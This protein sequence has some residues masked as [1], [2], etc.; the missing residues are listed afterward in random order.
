ME[1][2]YDVLVV[3]SGF[4]GSV[5]AL[6]LSE[7]GYRVAV[8]EQ[9]R[10]ISK[11]DM[12]RAAR[13][14][15]H[16]FWMPALHWAG[17]FT[18][19]FFQHVNVVGGV[20]VGGGSLVY[21][22]VLL[23]PKPGFFEHPAWR[24]LGVNWKERLQPYYT[25]AAQM[26]GRTPNPAFTQMDEYLRSTAEA[27]GAGETFGPAPLGIYFGRPGETVLDPFFQE[28]GPTRTGCIQCGACL[29]GCPH[30]A[31]N[32]LDTN[33]L[34]LAEARGAV[35]LPR[36]KAVRIQPL[37]QGGYEVQASDPLKPGG[38]KRTLRAPLVVLAAG[39]LGTLELLFRCRDECKTLPDLSPRLGEIVRTNSEAIVGILSP[40][41]EADLSR[42]PT[43]SS[44]FYVGEHT[45]I[46]QNRFPRGYSFMKWYTGPLVD[47]EQP[48]RRSL[49]SLF[50]F[51]RHPLQATASF[52]AL[53][54]YRRIS[55]LTVMQYLDNQISF[56]WS[57][58]L[59]TPL[60]KRLQSRPVPGKSAP[61]YLPVAN[62]VA[63]LFAE[64]SGGIP[65]NTLLESLFNM[66]VTAHI[67]GGCPIGKDSQNGVVDAGHEV[68][69]YPGMYIVDGSALPA[70]IGVNPA[71]T[72][73]A[74]AERAMSRIPPKG[75]VPE[76]TFQEVETL[77]TS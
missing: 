7:K 56:R 19:R 27:I 35:I 63:R 18:Q 45:H 30:N 9:G 2:D 66:S 21:A 31:K 65:Q 34:Y 36:H 43:I 13:S 59:F 12:D 48:L 52:R 11:L 47:G 5:A 39:V 46:T 68:F 61:T 75:Q 3:G 23:E 55:A 73:T 51:L 60:N 70:N 44:H 50:A 49:K 22:A 1:F 32:S 37:P 41:R 25:K 71:L 4:G 28:E 24:D 20:G 76:P 42:G 29:T 6:R 33:Y 10:R 54:W 17:F 26:L 74:L 67:L 40:D 38:I 69:G 77:R 62:Q 58:G 14:L 72:I 16:L 15:R 8:L 53:N 57:R 64:L